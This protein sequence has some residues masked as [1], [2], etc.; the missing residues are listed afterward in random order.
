MRRK[1]KDGE[2]D[3]LLTSAGVI[4]L[5]LSLVAGMHGSLAYK[6]AGYERQ[7][8]LRRTLER[9]EILG[10]IDFRRETLEKCARDETQM[11]NEFVASGYAPLPPNSLCDPALLN[12]D[13]PL[14]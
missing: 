12:L 11:N 4:L 2:R 9:K 5:S 14:E 6:E 8:E 3:F 1:E 13:P 7:R 10:H